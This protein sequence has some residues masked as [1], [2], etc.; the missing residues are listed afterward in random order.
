MSY[1]LWVTRTWRKPSFRNMSMTVS[2]G[3][4]SVTVIGARSKMR[5]NFNGS[6][7]CQGDG[8]LGVNKTRE[9]SLNPSIVRFAFAIRT[10]EQEWTHNISKTMNFNA[11]QLTFEQNLPTARERS[12]RRTKPTR[13]C[14]SL[15]TT[16]GKPLW[17]VSLS[18]ISTPSKVVVSCVK[19][20]RGLLALRKREKKMRKVNK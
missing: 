4:W 13:N 8:I 5:R 14:D 17:S 3:V 18:N 20:V 1:P 9:S 6:D 15:D 10:Q 11:H 2:I 7:P 16:T 12:R 19:T